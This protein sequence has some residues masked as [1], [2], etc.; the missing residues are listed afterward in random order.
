MEKIKKIPLEK[1]LGLPLAHDIT[2]VNVDKKS[3]IRAFKKGHIIKDIDLERLRRLG[4]NEI[5]VLSL[6]PEQIHE[7][8]AAVEMAQAFAG[9]YTAYEPEPREGKINFFAQKD[10]L[11]EIDTEKLLAINMLG[12]PSCVTKPQNL[13]VCQGTM[14][15]STRIIPLFCKRK[16]I[17]QAVKIANKTGLFRILPFYPKKA[18][19]IITGNEIYSG[20]IKD[21]F[22]PIIKKKLSLYRA[23]VISSTI[24]PDNL[25]KIIQAI[26][27]FITFGCETIVLTGGTS[28]DPDD[29]TA[30]AI[31]KA[32]GQD[33]IHGVPLQPGN[34][35]TL[36]WINNKKSSIPVCAVPA[37]ALFYPHTS[38][39]VFLPRLLVGK[40][41]TPKEIAALGLGGLCNFCQ[42]CIY[43]LCSFGR[44]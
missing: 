15:A 11:L 5:Y 13:P 8:E 27:D 6:T 21:G 30:S 12:G 9:H 35:L 4:K 25:D 28:V 33:F 37:A 7:D 22:L 2:E 14:I 1:A 44:G 26:H 29:L 38:F 34:M 43:P 18:G 16:T 3:K 32:G 17:K 41:P 39:D 20:K 24:L 40:K 31:K 10:G 36:A 42:T 23:T 19:V